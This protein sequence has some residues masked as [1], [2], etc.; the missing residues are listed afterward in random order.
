VSLES[1]ARDVSVR[2][3]VNL[4]DLNLLIFAKRFQYSR[5]YRCVSDSQDLKLLPGR[6][7]HERCVLNV[8]IAREHCAHSPYRTS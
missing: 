3:H 6:L 2:Y 4:L 8:S 5:W 1:R 7:V